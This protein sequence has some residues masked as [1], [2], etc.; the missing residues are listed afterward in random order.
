M[1]KRKK[2]DISFLIWLIF[3]SVSSSFD[4]FYNNKPALLSAFDKDF[5]ALTFFSPLIYNSK[6]ENF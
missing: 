3:C 5:A 6:S 1:N 2:L 4:D